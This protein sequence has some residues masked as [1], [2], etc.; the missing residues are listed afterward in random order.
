MCICVY[1]YVYVYIYT[2][3]Y[4]YVYGYGYVYLRVQ[5]MN[6]SSGVGACVY[7]AKFFKPSAREI[8]SQFRLGIFI[9]GTD[10]YGC[11]MRQCRLLPLHVSHMCVGLEGRVCYH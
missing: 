11:L 3:I 7:L 10:L 6:T 5:F 4:V 9:K 1:V 8:I 2:Y